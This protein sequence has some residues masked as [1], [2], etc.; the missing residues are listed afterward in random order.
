[1]HIF[2]YVKTTRYLK[3]HYFLCV[4]L[5][6]SFNRALSSAGYMANVEH[7]CLPTDL[8]QPEQLKDQ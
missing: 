2:V 8:Q 4:L 7:P 6:C 5:P 3:A 1:M